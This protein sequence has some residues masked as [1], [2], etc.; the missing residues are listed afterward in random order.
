MK[1]KRTRHPLTFALYRLWFGPEMAIRIAARL[2]G[3]AEPVSDERTDELLAY[4]SEV[5]NDNDRPDSN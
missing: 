5:K 3:E 2:D 1:T 4:F